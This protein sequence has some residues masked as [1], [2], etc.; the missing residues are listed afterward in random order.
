MS[1]TAPNGPV[2]LPSGFRS[3]AWRR[4]SGATP[5]DAVALFSQFPQPSDVEATGLHGTERIGID[6]ALAMTGAGADQLRLAIV[7]LFKGPK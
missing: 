4:V 2:A 3:S 5:H 6:N 7:D 1:S